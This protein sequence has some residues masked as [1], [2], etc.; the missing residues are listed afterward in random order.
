MKLNP[1]RTIAAALPFCLA[2]NWLAG[3]TPPP[4][5]AAPIPLVYVQTIAASADA[6][7]IRLPASV[8][9]R[10]ETDLA[11]RAGGQVRQRLVEA[12]SAVKAGQVLAT[13]DPADLQLAER[14]A[15]DQSQAARA[16]A[17]QA[18]REVA[19]LERLVADGSAGAADLERQ[20]ARLDAA[21]ARAAQAARQRELA[22]NRKRYGELRAPFDGV[23]TAWRLDVGATVAEG[24]SVV[25][26]ARTADLEIAAEVPE[27]MISELK[28]RPARATI[29]AA[30]VADLPLKLREL[31]PA[32]AG[33]GR[34][35][36]VRYSLGPAGKASTALAIGMSAQIVLHGARPVTGARLPAAALVKAAD[37]PFVWQAD[38]DAAKATLKTRPVQLLAQGADWVRV[39]GLADGT[40][41]VAA[42]A[43]RLREGLAVRWI[44]Q[45]QASVADARNEQ[46]R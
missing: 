44:E 45:P 31:A 36:R 40:R 15:D 25:S 35:Y 27:S 29:D 24:T 10:L 30:G 4:A 16:E 33:A 1:M 11:F 2:L 42:G 8:R 26:L 18:A 19:R 23:V 5:P 9:P 39:S 34:L 6:T 46:P 41:I 3:C 12:G 7:D 38:G 14:A 37:R 21:R 32:T 22:G 17:D 13:L 20:Q 28:A 43:H